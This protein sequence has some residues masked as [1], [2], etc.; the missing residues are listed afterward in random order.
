MCLASPHDL[1]LAS[2]SV[3]PFPS[4][5][6]LGRLNQRTS[7][8]AVANR[9]WERGPARPLLEVEPMALVQLRYMRSCEMRYGAD[10]VE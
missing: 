9:V 4:Q 5:S 6:M 2:I 8:A 3:A 7:A 1:R 10:V